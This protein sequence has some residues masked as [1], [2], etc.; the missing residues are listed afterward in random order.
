MG[1]PKRPRVTEQSGAGKDQHFQHFYMTWLT[2][3][4]PHLWGIDVVECEITDALDVD[5][6]TELCK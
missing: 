6:E 4:E 5:G 2:V 1:S 3:T